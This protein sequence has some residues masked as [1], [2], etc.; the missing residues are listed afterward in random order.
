M[1]ATTPGMAMHLAPSVS[2]RSDLLSLSSDQINVSPVILFQEWAHDADYKGTD[3]SLVIS[4]LEMDS[5]H[6]F[7]KKFLTRRA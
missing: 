3:I 6:S 4:D 7:F 2:V 1:R 5:L